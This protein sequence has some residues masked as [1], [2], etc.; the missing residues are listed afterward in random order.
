MRIGI[1]GH[2]GGKE[3]FNDGQ[4]VKV[5]SLY[6]GLKKVVSPTIIID[7]IDTY[8]LKQNRIKLILSLIRCVCVDKVIIFLPAT[9]GRKVLFK[10]MYYFSKF[11]KKEI[12]H[13]CIGGALVNE[14]GNHPEWSKYLNGFKSNWMESQIQV[15]KL[16]EIGIRNAEYIPNFKTIEP[17][18]VS[19][20]KKEFE[21]P[22]RFCTFSRVLPEKGIEDA[23]EAIK[24]VND[25]FNKKV[26]VLDVFGPIQKGSE[27]W[28]E[29]LMLK[30]SDNM[31]Y[32]GSVQASES[33]NIL[34]N[35]FSLLFP[36]RYFTEGMPGTIIDAMFSGVP[37]IS[38]KWA[39]CEQMITNNYNGLFYDFDKPELL[40]EIILGCVKNPSEIIKM[41]ENC[42]IEAQKYTE[43]N[44]ISKIVSIIEKR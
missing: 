29:E 8:Y 41:R 35:Y 40:S 42:L 24:N 21:L 7:R 22:L 2:F 43:K 30:Y 26:A 11:L 4:T 10:L 20:L 27:E 44:V 36:T 5:K 31:V 37:V 14:L 15:E 12:Y 25:I 39:Y 16:L 6:Y 18:D 9:N 28:F 33:V 1:I 3:V 34:K 32:C 19:E 23:A 38:R 13:D 17:L